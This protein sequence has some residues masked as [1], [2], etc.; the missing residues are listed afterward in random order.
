MLGQMKKEQI[1]VVFHI[2][3]EPNEAKATAIHFDDTHMNLK[4]FAGFEAI[5][6]YNLLT[7]KE[8]TDESC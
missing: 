3:G 5:D 2:S 8:I 4:Q 1:M 7:G 6:I